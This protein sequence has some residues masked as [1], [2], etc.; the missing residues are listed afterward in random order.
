MSIEFEWDENKNQA[1]RDKHGVS[2]E[3]ARKIWDG[4]YLEFPE[5][6]QST[7]G[8]ERRATMGWI[9]GEV[10]IGIWTM[11]EDRIR[12]ISVRRARSYEKEIFSDAF[13]NDRGDGSIS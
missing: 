6:V 2:F 10:Y 5:I 4:N 13:Q 9:E 11:R 12:L 1:N 8:E 3:E 7:G